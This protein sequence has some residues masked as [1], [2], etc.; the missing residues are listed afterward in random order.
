LPPEPFQVYRIGTLADAYPVPG[1]TID[2][3]V[4]MRRLRWQPEH[5]VTTRMASP[6]GARCEKNAHCAIPLTSD[7]DAV[8]TAETH[9][10]WTDAAFNRIVAVA[11]AHGPKFRLEQLTTAQGDQRQPLK[12]ARSSGAPSRAGRRPGSRARLLSTGGT[13]HGQLPEER[14]LESRAERLT[15]SQGQFHLVASRR[16]ERR[17]GE[18]LECQTAP[19]RR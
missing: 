17:P 2:P 10:A 9:R 12:G 7:P 1:T 11:N 18:E 14:Y 6:S 4:R 13:A 3:A 15:P 5:P 8:Q 19:A 16:K